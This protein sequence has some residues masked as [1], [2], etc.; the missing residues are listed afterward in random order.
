MSHNK[1][2]VAL[3]LASRPG[4]SVE[5]SGLCIS[6][7]L[8][9]A[10][11][12]CEVAAQVEAQAEAAS[13]IHSQARLLVAHKDALRAQVNQLRKEADNKIK[14]LGK[15]DRA[16]AYANETSN[17][18]PLK[19]LLDPSASKETLFENLVD[20]GVEEQEARLLCTVPASWQK[21]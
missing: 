17:F 9:E 19:I 3:A 21:S 6:G 12:A 7:S 8:A 18:L 13:V 5:E 10:V 4:R 1:I 16:V 11:L 15:L 20:Q 14:E 2:L